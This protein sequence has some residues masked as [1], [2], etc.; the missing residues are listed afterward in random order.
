MSDG[1]QISWTDAT[2]NPV[3]GCTKVSPGCDHCYIDRTPPFRMQHRRFDKPGI[4]GTTGVQ[5]HGDR[6]L[7]PLHWRK[8]RRIFV[9]SLSDLFH[10]DIPGLFITSVFAT[11]QRT[12]QHSYQVLTK[13]P[14]R[15]R[16]LLTSELF[17]SKVSWPLPNV[18]LGVSTEDQ[19]T[20]D[21]RIPIL[22]ETPAAVRWI[23]AEPLLGPIRLPRFCACGCGKLYEDACR[24]A[25]LYSGWL[26]P[27]QAEASV[28]ST[29]GLDWVVVGGESGP[30]ARPAHPDWFRTLR[31]QC[32]AAG[33]PFHFKQRGEWT[34]TSRPSDRWGDRDPDLWVEKS[35]G[36]IA[37]EAVAVAAGG[38]WS[39][40]Y[41]VGKKVAGRELDGV[42]HEAY[43]DTRPAVLL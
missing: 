32:S 5:L 7:Q 9:N 4:G 42:L 16:S 19:K 25:R 28:E 23:S 22:L 30:G 20:A 29:L 21:L 6:L 41:R 11:M 27:D 43:P 31:D 35:D 36:R 38:S 14:A 40:V 15:M 1:T 13:R 34:W 8:P 17:R 39:G 33:V 12:P 24:S 18:W 10:A 3:T 37:T 26:N 2:W